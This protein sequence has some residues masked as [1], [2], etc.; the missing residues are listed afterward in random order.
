VRRTELLQHVLLAPAAFIRR[1]AARCPTVQG[2]VNTEDATIVAKLK[3]AGAVIIGKLNLHEFALGCT[4]D[5]S[6]FGPSR[7]PWNLAFVTGGSSAGS[8]SALAS[9]LVFGALGTDT[10]GSIR[11]PSAWCGTVGLKPTTGLV[12]IRGIIPCTADLDH[13]GPMARTVEDVALMLDPHD[14]RFYNDLA[15]AYDQLE[16]HRQAEQLYREAIRL[17]PHSAIYLKNLGTNLMAQQKFAKGSEAYRQALSIDPHI[18]DFRNTPTMAL[19]RKD[20][21]ET[22]YAR[23]RSCAQDGLVDCTVVYL[24]KALDEGSATPRRI[25]SDARFQAVLNTPEVQ[26][27]LTEQR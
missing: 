8:A 26:L 19:P 13:C 20:N 1:L 2:D 10:G 17:D 22:N 25:A 7:N 4:G 24:R 18:L 12:S 27:L 21:A 23:A 11:V 15:T 3:T 14:A 9:D 6:Y 5:V 16:D